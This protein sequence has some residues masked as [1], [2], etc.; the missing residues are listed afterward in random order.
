M[1]MLKKKIY[2]LAVCVSALFSGC[3]LT[4]D[5][6][7]V[8]Y[9]NPSVW[10]PQIPADSSGVSTVKGSARTL[11]TDDAM[12][13]TIIP[14]S[15]QPTTIEDIVD[16]NGMV[17]LPLVGEFLIGGITTSQ[18]EKKIREAYVDG[19]L[20]KDVTVTVVCKN[21]V[22]ERVV[23]I[24]GAINRK[25]AV[26]FTDG[27]TLR[28]AIVTAGDRTPYASSEVRITRDGN[29]SKHNIY[30]IENSKESDPVLKPNDMI[31]V[32]ERWL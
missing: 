5:N 28:M 21:D 24:S 20:Y 18:A 29:I 27:M 16:A 1:I 32:V 6:G 25:G 31:E 4:T 10:R 13:I 2:F 17:S 22:H 8:E 30:R 26:P 12:L 15:L 11:R 23:Y 9:E 3:F 19:G 7:G 14:G